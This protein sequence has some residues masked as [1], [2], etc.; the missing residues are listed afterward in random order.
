MLTLILYCSHNNRS[1][2]C[3]HT[4]TVTPPIR[5]P[6]PL[7]WCVLFLAA[8]IDESKLTA[9]TEVI[10]ST[11]TH[12]KTGCQMTFDDDYSAYWVYFINFLGTLA[13]LP[14]NIVSALLMDK[15]GRL[16]MLG[17]SP[18]NVICVSVCV[19]VCVRVCVFVFLFHSCVRAC[20][21]LMWWGVG[22]S[23]AAW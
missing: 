3:V 10:N 12:N 18:G 11:F 20:R 8:D 7:C 9:G 1:K 23:T 16:S 5:S 6:S 22:R 2:G 21:G 4:H 15:I 13:V 14:G 19:C 17:T